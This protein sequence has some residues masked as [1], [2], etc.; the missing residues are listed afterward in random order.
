M[1][2]VDAARSLFGGT[3]K[4]IRELSSSTVSHDSFD[5]GVLDDFQERATR[6]RNT[7]E[8]APEVRPHVPLPDRNDFEDEADYVKAQEEAVE[9]QERAEAVAGNYSGWQHDVKDVF[10]AYHT[11]DEPHVKDRTEVKPSREL[12]RQ[13]MQRL[14]LADKFAEGRPHT[15]H[16]DVESAL[17]TMAFSEKLREELETTL[18]EHVAKSE[19]ASEQEERLDNM[20]QALEGLREQAKE[21]YDEHGQVEE[22]LVEQV[23]QAVRERKE[24]RAGLAETAEAIS[25]LPTAAI[26]QAVDEAASDAAEEAEA[27][28]GIPGVGPGMDSRITPEQAFALATRWRENERLRE[29]A[30]LIGKM[31]RDMR[32]AR[33]KR[34]TGGREEV[35]DF[36]HGN[37]LALVLPHELAAA[38]HPILKV[39]FMRRYMERSLLQYEMVGEDQAGLGPVIIVCDGSGSMN[40]DL[41]GSSRNEWARAL[42]LATLSIV[43][44]EKRDF[45]F[46]EYSYPKDCVQSWFFPAKEPVDAERVADMAAHFFNGG[47]ETIGGLNEAM[48]IIHGVPQFKAADV[49]L[50][51]DGDDS[52]SSQAEDRVNAMRELG[53]RIQGIAVATGVTHYLREACEVVTPIYG[54]TDSQG[55][56]EAVAN[57]LNP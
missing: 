39:D 42:S 47:T 51:S 15:R 32:F 36:E 38:A 29:I 54:M 55:A 12:G 16:S 18:A 11:W 40:A 20:E 30:K 21:Q 57:T 37:D 26:G 56:T 17:A 19:E 43:H 35:V 33:A 10:R 50:I 22:E 2:V 53:V 3:R 49:L 46:V 1:K 24:A 14:T 5:D 23:K 8:D 9:A 27:V 6:F 45:A 13:L 48:T 44:E 52:W 7:I 31:R 28:A 4:R 41:G 25:Q 34:I